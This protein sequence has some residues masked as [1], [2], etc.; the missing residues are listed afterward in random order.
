M[1]LFWSIF[2]TWSMVGERETLV[3]KL[4]TSNETRMELGGGSWSNIM[5]EEKIHKIKF[6]WIPA[7]CGVPGHDIVDAASR[8]QP[9][10][11]L[12][13]LNPP[14]LKDH[15]SYL[16]DSAWNTESGISQLGSSGPLSQTCVAGLQSLAKRAASH[17]YW[18][19]QW[20]YSW[21]DTHAPPM[22]IFSPAN[23]HQ[24]VQLVTIHLRY[25]TS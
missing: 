22:I 1:P 18:K 20:T 7:H 2:L 8:T 24:C 25:Y 16:L 4:I 9:I 19:L 6:V 13:L 10:I 12:P 21:L 17:G 23:R 14:D 5:M 15:I 3:N 11:S